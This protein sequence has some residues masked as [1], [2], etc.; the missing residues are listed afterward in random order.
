MLAEEGEHK[1][2]AVPVRGGDLAGLDHLQV[3]LQVDKVGVADGYLVF[4]GFV[5][6][7]GSSLLVLVLEKGKD[8]WTRSERLWAIRQASMAPNS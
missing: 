4:D 5:G 6:H 2:D 8:I 7:L 1:P 3:V